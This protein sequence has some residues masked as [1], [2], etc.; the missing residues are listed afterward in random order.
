[1]IVTDQNSEQKNRPKLL[2]EVRQ[3]ALEHYG[4]QEPVDR[5]VAWAKRFI[6]FHE[7]RHPRDLDIREVA[8]F[9]DH[10]AKSEKDPLNALDQAREALSFL[11]EDVLRIQIG[12]LPMPK[13]PMLLDRLRHA[14]RVR[15]YS[16]R[17]ESCYVVWTL[18]YMRFH[19]MR[20]PRTMGGAEMEMFLG[21]T[22][23][24]SY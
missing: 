20:H 6:L 23:F 1:M 15:H 12:E 4:R 7:K 22:L 24:Q 5:H 16:P 9:L 17:T 2:D 19:R 8:R 14:I 13:P 18:R 3:L 21:P 10:I 11:Y